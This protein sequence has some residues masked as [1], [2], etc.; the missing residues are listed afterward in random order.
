MTKCTIL[1]IG[2]ELLIGQVIDTNSAWIAQKLNAHGISVQSRIAVGD[3][4]TQIISALQQAEQQS[5]IIFITGG[6]GGTL[7]D[8]TKKVLCTYFNSRLI[9]HEPTLTHIRNL[10]EQK[11]KRA[12]METNLSQAYV[13]EN[14][15]VLPN[16][17]GSAPGMLFERNEKRFFSLPGVPLEMEGIVEEEIVPFLRKH[18]PQTAI[19][20]RTLLCYGIS[21]SALAAHIHELEISLPTHISLAYLPAY[22]QIRLRLSTKEEVEKPEAGLLDEAFDKLKQSVAPWLVV[23][24][25]I[26]M[27]EVV[28]NL[29][30]QK[31]KT[32]S[33]AESCTGG[34]IAHQ[35]TSLPGSSAY[36]EGSVVSYSYPAKEKLLGVKK[37]TLETK[38]AV[39]EAV[40]IEMARGILKNLN[41]DY[42]LAV[43]GI[44]GPG[45]GMPGKPVGTVWIAVG[46]AQKIDTRMFTL[47]HDRINNIKQTAIH[48]LNQIRRFILE[49]NTKG[50]G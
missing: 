10:F 17:R 40:V 9:L 47:H 29:L 44:M 38:G 1:T 49:E 6:L 19:Q 11:F 4:E 5:E 13:P 42:A 15:I 34:Y 37:E 43:S 30:K 46:S 8:I 26:S 22:G 48:A 20:H 33:T 39:S 12:P 45:G 24:E 16:Q 27:V 32:I 2:D 21:E 3:D 18:Y 23:D 25:D 36:F 50:T 7:D 14:C 35:F 28:S 31:N 41:T